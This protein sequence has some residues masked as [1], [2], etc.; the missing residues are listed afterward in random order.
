MPLK[1]HR[2][3]PQL[4]LSASALLGLL[5]TVWVCLPP[6]YKN[7]QELQSDYGQTLANLTAKRVVDASFKGDLVRL[8]GVLQELVTHPHVVQATI[9]DVDSNLLVQAGEARPAPETH[10]PYSASIVLHDSLSGYITVTLA[11][12]ENKLSS[13]VKTVTVI[14]LFLVL[15]MAYFVIKTDTVVWIAPQEKPADIAPNEDEVSEV[16]D[17]AKETITKEQ[18]NDQYVYTAIHVKNLSVL[19][20]QLNSETFRL[21]VAKLEAIISDVIALY[22]GKDFQAQENYYSLRFRT[23]DGL[24]E[25]IFRASC[26]AYII[27]ELASIINKIPLDLAAFVSAN[28]ND[29]VPAKLPVAGLVM[30]ATAAQEDLIQ[31]RL[32]FMEVGTEDG[33]YIVANFEQ[34]FSQLLENQRKQLAKQFS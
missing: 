2:P 1:F 13:S 23:D 4:L 12:F 24:N 19:K 26:S 3:P 17:V 14:G 16:G 10:S 25:S 9:H 21:T 22:G 34:P 27:V 32:Q 20:Q 29:I 5:F 30:D 28:E 6:A 33:R 11:N 15:I 18:D 31:R 7:F 8:Q